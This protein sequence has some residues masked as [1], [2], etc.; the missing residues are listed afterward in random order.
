MSAAPGTK[1]SYIGVFLGNILYGF[2]VSVFLESSLLLWRKQKGR[3]AS[4]IYV[5]VTSAVMFILIT[6]RCVIDTVRCILAFNNQGLSFGPPNTT[7]GVVSNACWLLVTAVADA[8]LAYIPYLHRVEEELA[9]YNPSH[10]TLPRQFRA[11]WILYSFITF[12]VTKPIFGPIT[13]SID[14]FSYLT[15]FTN[16]LCSALISFRIFSVRRKVT[17]L[18]SGSPGRSDDIT[19][20]IVSIMVESAATYTLLLVVQ[21]V[22]SSLDSYISYI[23]TDCTP[24]TIGIV[25]S[26][27][28][29]R[30]S[31]GS[32]YGD[33][34]TSAV[35]T[36]LSRERANGTFE[37]S[38]RNPLSGTRSEVQV[39]LERTIHQ[40]S[41]ADEHSV[42]NSGKYVE[43]LTGPTRLNASSVTSMGAV[44]LSHLCVLKLSN[45]AAKE[46][47]QWD[48]ARTL[49]EVSGVPRPVNHSRSR[50]LWRDCGTRYPG[51][52][53]LSTISIMTS[54]S[55]SRLFG[56]LSRLHRGTSRACIGHGF[57]LTDELVWRQLHATLLEEMPNYAFYINR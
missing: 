8:F 24:A 39:K 41:D 52:L 6:M 35:P 2:Y 12:D 47:L 55:F 5:I 10:I 38:T 34:T 25:F 33:S 1:D 29:I 42:T 37:L 48:N 15:L 32:S 4:N 14:A 13:M 26:Y 20:K 53:H 36:G 27:I 54:G 21:L 11:I 16:L 51:R 19:T 17:G 57:K 3:N 56:D 31:R 40:H 9:Y 46:L 30:V 23:A 50:P 49:R 22:T 43:E 45:T 28:I 7:L 18:V 44:N